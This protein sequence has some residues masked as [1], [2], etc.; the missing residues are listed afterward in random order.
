YTRVNRLFRDIPAHHIQA[1]VKLGNLREVVQAELQRRG[2]RCGCIRCREV[3]RRKVSAHEL[4]LQTYT[5]DTDLTCEHFLQ[6]V[7]NEESQEPGL[8]A[9]FLR[10]SLPHESGVGSRGFLD[11][12]ANTAMIREV[13]VYGPA[14]SLDR[15]INEINARG[16]AQ[17]VGLGTQLL[18]KAR[19]ISREAGFERISVIA[20]T[21]TRD[22][23][24]QRGFEQG[25][26]YM[27][28][29]L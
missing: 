7:T 19:A 10:L 13:H 11:E 26:L 25:E 2:E 28:S 27:H 14:L 9:G 18:E 3:K 6:F 1:G 17:H 29:A 21:G 12:I 15:D 5:Y 8:I 16:A 24:A 23:Y 20:A 22:Y 4:T